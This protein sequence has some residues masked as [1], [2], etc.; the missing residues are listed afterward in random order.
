MKLLKTAAITC[1]ETAIT[2]SQKYKFQMGLKDILLV[3]ELVTICL[4]VPFI[5]KMISIT[6]FA[7]KIIQYITCSERFIKLSYF[8]ISFGF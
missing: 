6:W 8:H 7:V 4:S 3:S 5:F 2:I 1:Q